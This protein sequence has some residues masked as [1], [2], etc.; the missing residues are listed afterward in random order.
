M[1]NA[2]MRKKLTAQI[3]YVHTTHP[4]LGQVEILFDKLKEVSQRWVDCRRQSEM[5]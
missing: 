1:F 4:S 3:D 2:S 5:R